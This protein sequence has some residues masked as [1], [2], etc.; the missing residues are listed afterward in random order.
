MSPLEVGPKIR[1]VF[2]LSTGIHFMYLSNFT[3]TYRQ[4]RRGKTPSRKNVRIVIQ[5]L[6]A[7]AIDPQIYDH[8]FHRR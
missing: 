8:Y 6:I 4:A 1:P 7:K 5:L 3:A 2:R